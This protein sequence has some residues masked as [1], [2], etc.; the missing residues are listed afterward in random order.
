MSFLQAENLNGR[1]K[2]RDNIYFEAKMSDTVFHIPCLKKVE[3]KKSKS[4]V[5]FSSLI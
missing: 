5:L 1:E 3:V 2:K 4:T